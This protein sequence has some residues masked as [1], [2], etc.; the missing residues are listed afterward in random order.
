M[1]FSPPL[2]KGTLIKR[3]KRF[4][5][6]ITL[7]DG[8]QIT[9]SSP[10]TGSMLGL[11]APGSTVYVSEHDS[12]TR[13]YRHCLEI[14]EADIGD[15]PVLVGINTSHPNRL[16]ADALADGKI[17]PLKGYANHRREV[18][19]GK[20]SRIDILLEDARKG[21][22]Y[23]EIKNTHLM[24]RSG[25]AEFPDSVTARGAKHLDELSEMVRAGQRAVMMFL[26]QRADAKRCAIAA[27]IDPAYAE[28]FARAQSAGVEALAYR[29][30]VGPDEI[31]VERKIP[32]VSA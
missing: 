9:A 25:L 8:S 19:Y 13:K 2:V 20:N 4:L 29:C 11:T 16:V 7:Q 32:I 10:N 27:D 15:G 30:R 3:Y 17:A 18:K 24:R 21:A 5:A 22:C 12:P 6:D 31:A 1:K 26:I 14:V 23:L 28:A